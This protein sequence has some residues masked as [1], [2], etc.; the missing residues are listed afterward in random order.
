MIIAAVFSFICLF[1]AYAAVIKF[2]S[3]ANGSMS[4]ASEKILNSLSI[5]NTSEKNKLSG[6]SQNFIKTERR[7]NLIMSVF[8]LSKDIQKSDNTIEFIKMFRTG[9]SNI[10]HFD[11]SELILNLSENPDTDEPFYKIISLA[12]GSYSDKSS[13]LIHSKIFSNTGK[14]ILKENAVYLYYPDKNEFIEYRGFSSECRLIFFP[15]I[16]FDIPLGGLLLKRD[17]KEFEIFEIDSLSIFIK[18]TAT[19]FRNIQLLNMV[20]NLIIYDTLTGLFV[21][22]YFKIKLDEEIVRSRTSKKFFCILVCDIDHFKIVNDT[23][24]HQAGDIVLKE[25]GKIIRNAIR[26]VDMP[27]RYG[28]D[29]FS[30]ILPHTT[31]DGALIL[32]NRICEKIRNVSIPFYDKKLNITISIGVAEFNESIMDSNE[33]IRCADTALYSCKSKGRN[34]VEIF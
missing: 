12:D 3:L 11:H 29:E 5:R 8:E 4:A 1:G 19:I 13:S 32:A 22:K 25:T 23:Y 9:L 34:R 26:T 20:N 6:Y 28:G 21:H 16:S 27:A 18:Q 30:V 33:L 10:I 31:K 7:A 17:S 24:G 2:F 14:I 15:I